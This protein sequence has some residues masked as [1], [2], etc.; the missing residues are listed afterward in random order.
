MGATT[1]AF[2]FVNTN[3]QAITLSGYC[4]GGDAAVYRDW[5]TGQYSCTAL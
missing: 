2:T 3:G 1:P 5:E 4:A